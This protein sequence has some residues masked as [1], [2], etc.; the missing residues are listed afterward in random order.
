MAEARFC[1][2]EP[3]VLEELLALRPRG[4][5]KP[6]QMYLLQVCGVP[7]HHGAGHTC[8]RLQTCPGMPPDVWGCELG[9]GQGAC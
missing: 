3:V 8:A 5:A 7:G 9:W 6:S 2:P 1:A 4:Q